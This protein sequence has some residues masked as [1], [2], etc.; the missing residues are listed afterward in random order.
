MDMKQQTLNKTLNNSK[1][2]K[3]SFMEKFAK[4]AETPISD[5]MPENFVQNNYDN[6]KDNINVQLADN[7][8]NNQDVSEK[9]SQLEHK[10]NL[11][12][13]YLTDQGQKNNI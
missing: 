12:Y 11:I 2:L 8:T 1:D 10:L 5:L 13:E 3:I 7:I 6:S 9:L 4:A